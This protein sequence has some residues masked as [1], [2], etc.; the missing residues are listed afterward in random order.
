MGAIPA[1]VLALHDWLKEE[2]R[3]DLVSHIENLLGAKHNDGS[4]IGPERVHEFL[5]FDLDD[6]PDVDDDPGAN[7]TYGALGANMRALQR[8]YETYPA[9]PGR[10]NLSDPGPFLPAQAAQDV[11]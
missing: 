9:I 1:E 6:V 5:Y 3:K 2:W 11:S 10:L 8:L 4:E 7:Y